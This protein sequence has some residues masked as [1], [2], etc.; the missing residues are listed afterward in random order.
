M[1]EKEILYDKEAKQKLIDGVNSVANAVKVTLGA[2]GRN[3]IIEDERGLPHVTKDGVTVANSINLSDPVENLGA[4]IIKQASDRSARNSGDGTTTT[5]VLT[6]A[7]IKESFD[8]IDEN[9]NITQFK[10]GMEDACV[11]VVKSLKDQSKKVSNKTLKSVSRISANND[12]ELGNIIAEAYIKVGKDGV[13]TMEESLNSDT[14]VSVID[15]TKIKKGYTSPYMVTNPEK[16]EAILD[17]PL[18]FI[19]DQEVRSLEDITNVLE[20]AIKNKRSIL[21]IADVETAVMNAL[22]VNKAKGVIKVNVIAPEGIGI[23]RFELLE[24]LC[25]LTGAVLASDETGNDLSAVDSSYLGEAIKSISTTTDTVLIVDRPKHKI[26]IDERLKNINLSIANAENR[27]NLW[28]YKDRLSRL[29]GGVAVVHVGANSE[30]EMKEKK[31]R[32]DDAIHAV[33]SA[34]EEGILPGGGISLKNLKIKEFPS[35]A[36]N[37]YRAGWHSVL[38]SLSYPFAQIIDNSG[39][40]AKEVSSNLDRDRYSFGYNVLIEEFGDMY[41]MGVID[42]TKVVRNAIENAVSVSATLL[43]TE[44]TVTNKRA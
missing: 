44:A 36:N 29:S 2:A 18:V 22:N 19:S 28:H 35:L 12:T 14:Y 30:L 33:K 10:K 31:D 23:K 39:A 16:Q 5:C 13:V 6:Q 40:D 27:M 11:A 17:N 7:L 24:D 20:V 41:K 9:T 8:V 26:D 42:S 32:V 37:S 25:A 38:K 43:T 21:I 4:S 1:I 15:G 34:L 3:V